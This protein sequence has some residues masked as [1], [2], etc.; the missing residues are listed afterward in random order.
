M[1]PG[2]SQNVGIPLCHLLSYQPGSKSGNSLRPVLRI[3]TG[4]EVGRKPDLHR[5]PRS[6]E[7]QPI[8]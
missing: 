7:N 5:R 4:V 2:D 8:S 3:C 6:L 1:K